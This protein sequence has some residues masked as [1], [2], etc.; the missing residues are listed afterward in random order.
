MKIEAAITLKGIVLASA[1]RAGYDLKAGD[2]GYPDLE[3]FEKFW[4]ELE[5]GL[6]KWFREH[7]DKP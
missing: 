5:P 4:A 1:L 3:G 2:D 6:H 7:P